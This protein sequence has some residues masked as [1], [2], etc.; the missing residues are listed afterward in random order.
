MIIKV[1]VYRLSHFCVLQAV[2]VVVVAV[3]VSYMRLRW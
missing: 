3:H 1:I 2:I